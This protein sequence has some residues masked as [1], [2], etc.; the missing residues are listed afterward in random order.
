MWRESLKRGKVRFVRGCALNLRGGEN[1]IRFLQKLR[2]VE[3]LFKRYLH[4]V[5]KAVV[6]RVSNL[7]SYLY[8]PVSGQTIETVFY[9]RP[10]W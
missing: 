4:L 9:L 7:Q 6:T 2:L 10:G 1:Y 5:E 8:A 3:Q